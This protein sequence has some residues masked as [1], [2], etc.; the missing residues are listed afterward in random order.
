MGTKMEESSQQEKSGSRKET[1]EDG[2]LE[3]VFF[4]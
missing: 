3:K 2:D 1:E 4:F